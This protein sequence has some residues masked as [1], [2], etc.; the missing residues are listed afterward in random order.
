MDLLRHTSEL[1]ASQAEHSLSSLLM[2]VHLSHHTSLLDQ[3]LQHSAAL[4]EALE[5]GHRFKMAAAS[6]EGVAEGGMVAPDELIQQYQ[7]L[8]DRQKRLAAEVAGVKAL[9]ELGE[10]LQ[11]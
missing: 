11:V 3:L 4:L 1:E 10:K 9:P 5:A 7:D 2:G 8:V 6:E